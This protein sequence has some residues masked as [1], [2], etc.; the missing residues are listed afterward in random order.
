MRSPWLRPALLLLLLIAVSICVGSGKR[1]LG[2]VTLESFSRDHL[3]ARF[4]SDAD[5]RLSADE[6]QSVRAAFADIDVP[7]LPNEPYD[8]ATAAR[9][10]HALPDEWTLSDTTP[11]DNPITDAGAALGRVLFYDRQLSR[12][13]TVSCA[14]C[15]LQRA[16]FADPRRVSVG[17]E[18]GRTTR[19]AMSLVN[20]RYS[21]VKHARPG[22]FWDERAA[23]LE[24]QALMP[25]Q[26]QLEMGMTLDELETKLQ[27]LPYYPPL[28]QQAFG[29]PMVSRQAIAR[30]MAQFLR[31]LNSWDSRFDRAAAELPPGEYATP[32]KEFSEQENLGKKLFIE[33][34]GG[35]AEFGCAFCHVPPGFG[36]PKSFNNGLDRQYDDA[37]LGALEVPSNDPFTPS[38]H[39]KF[40]SP[41][42]RNIELTAPYM[43]DG[44]FATLEQVVQHYSRGIHP[45]ENLGLIF[46]GE[47]ND[48]G[49]AGFGFDQQQQ[50]AL[51]AFL[52]TLT[53]Q[54]FVTDP[55][56]SDPFIR[57]TASPEQP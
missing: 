51:V 33:G 57:A 29:S 22:F 7:M 2:Q 35:V 56:F 12:N 3:L 25:I 37:G 20:L 24:Q 34:L 48:A 16:A 44:R 30:A 31:S 4:D 23:T 28:F 49:T 55:K 8:Y 42:L 54:Q 50:T 41:S 13:N 46:Q 32:F 47:E 18:G 21:G 15:H 14:S 27:A 53:D 6:R 10:A 40:K 45:H 39:G 5:G 17:Y 9:P 11:A 43:H 36:M 52:K 38:N 1:V 19:N 26:D